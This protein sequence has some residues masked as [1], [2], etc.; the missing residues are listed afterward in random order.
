MSTGT[1]PFSFPDSPSPA[2]W[3]L[4][5]LGAGVLVLVIGAFGVVSGR[6]E[7]LARMS[8]AD[9]RLA[10]GATPDAP[11]T[12]FQR[13]ESLEIYYHVVLQDVPLGWRLDLSCEWTD[14]SGRVARHNRYQTKIVYKNT[15][16]T[17]CRQHFGEAAAV[18]PWHV[19]MITE[20]RVLSESSFVLK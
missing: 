4:M 7:K 1:S 15:W 3:K 18:G 16:P 13:R 12:E 2:R 17:H 9:A 5:L 20:D 8:T 19:R 11:L 14:P 10:L 6:S